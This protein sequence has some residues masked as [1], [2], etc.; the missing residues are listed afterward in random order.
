MLRIGDRVYCSG[1]L[2]LTVGASIA[3]GYNALTFYIND[4]KSAGILFAVGLTLM[5]VGILQH[6]LDRDNPF[7]HFALNISLVLGAALVRSGAQVLNGGIVVDVYVIALTLQ[8]ILVRIELSQIDHRFVCKECQR[9][10]C[11]DS[12]NLKRA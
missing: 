11:K 8:I 4:Q 2:G 12:F 5:V 9:S 7:I 10:P 1:C 6:L 3:V